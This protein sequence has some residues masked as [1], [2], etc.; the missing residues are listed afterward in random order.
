MTKKVIIYSK[1]GKSGTY[2]ASLQG[3]QIQNSSRDKHK[4]IG[5]VEGRGRE[6]GHI[7]AHEQVEVKKGG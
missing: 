2:T 6:G 7:R 4:A 5:K 1:D 3:T